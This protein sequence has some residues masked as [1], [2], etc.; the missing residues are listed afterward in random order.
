[1]RQKPHEEAAD[2]LVCVSGA[3][4]GLAKDW[5]GMVSQHEI[6]ALLSEVFING[7]QEEFRH[8]LN[9]KMAR[10]GELTEEQMY[11]AVKRHEVYLGRTKCLGGGGSTTL[12]ST[13]KSTPQ[14]TSTNTYKSC[15]QKTTAFVAA[16]MEESELTPTDSGLDASEESSS[17]PNDPASAAEGASQNNSSKQSQSTGASLSAYSAGLS[18]KGGGSVKGAKNVPCLNPDQFMHLIGPKNWGEASIDNEPTTCLLDN[19]AQLN[20]MTPDYAIKQGFQIFTLERLAQEIRGELPP[21]YGIGGIQVKPTGFVIMN[22]RIPCIQGYNE[23]QIAIVLDDPSMKECPFILG[24]PT[25]YRVIQVI[26]ESEINQLATPWA[27]LP[28]SYLIRGLQAWV[29]KEVQTDVG[30]KNIT[31][32]SVDEVV[33]VITKFQIPL[34]GCKAIHGRTGLLL[35]GYKLNVMTHGL[36]KRSPQLPLGGSQLLCHPHYREQQDYRCVEK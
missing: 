9:S 31:P 26:K 14:Q 16:P 5:K 29:G 13:Q 17:K 10:Y 28:L 18:S 30:N 25:L 8:V 24:T 21:I 4:D 22:V 2:F 34:F 35:M 3:V 27:M 36:E 33:R 1:M 23:D 15:F 6:K 7:L 12:T 19:G 32:T 20:F 11:N